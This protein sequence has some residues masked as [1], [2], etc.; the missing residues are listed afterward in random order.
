MENNIKINVFPITE[1]MY[2]LKSIDIINSNFLSLKK[3]HDTFDDFCKLNTE[4]QVTRF[5]IEN[6]TAIDTDDLTVDHIRSRQEYNPEGALIGEHNWTFE[7]SPDMFKYKNFII[8]SEGMSLPLENIMC[9]KDDQDVDTLIEM[10]NTPGKYANGTV[11]IVLNATGEAINISNIDGT[12]ISV[13]NG[14]GRTLLQNE[15]HWFVI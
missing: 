2:Q 6:A 1:D 7:I 12:L 14:E 5:Y 4:A 13:F 10:I 3:W 15:G 9:I 11:K 8:D